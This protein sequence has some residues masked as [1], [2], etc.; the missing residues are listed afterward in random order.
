MYFLYTR[1]LAVGLHAVA[2]TYKIILYISIYITVYFQKKNL[3]IR[4]T[5]F[6]IFESVQ[7]VSRFICVYYFLVEIHTWFRID[8]EAVCCIYTCTAMAVVYIGYT[9]TRAVGNWILVLK[10]NWIYSLYYYIII[11][12]CQLY[13][14]YYYV[15]RREYLCSS[16]Y[17]L[18]M[19]CRRFVEMICRGIGGLQIIEILRG[20]RGCRGSAP[21]HNIFHKLITHIQGYSKFML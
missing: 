7:Y 9:C 6:L 14:L 4:R 1:P 18:T 8:P 2:G 11:P 16:K 5:Y 10:Q 13:V 19:S 21:R 12:T 17:L 15:S 3:T 20:G